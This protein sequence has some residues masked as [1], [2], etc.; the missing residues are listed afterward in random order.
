MSKPHPPPRATPARGGGKPAG[1][2]RRALLERVRCVCVRARAVRRWA[3]ER[4][5][6]HKHRTTGEPVE[7]GQLTS[8]GRQRLSGCRRHPR[9]SVS[10]LVRNRPRVGQ[11]GVCVSQ[12]WRSV[13]LCRSQAAR[14]AL[15]RRYWC[16]VRPARRWRRC[17]HRQPPRTRG[18]CCPG[19][20]GAY[21]A[22]CRCRV[23]CHPRGR[24]QLAA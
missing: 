7:G 1:D 13:Q 19:R 21:R 5:W 17:R 15:S 9:R 8:T 16:S 11:K 23:S 6:L 22:R 14:V 12:R 10:N 20:S 2:D 3:G 4:R 18:R 24:L